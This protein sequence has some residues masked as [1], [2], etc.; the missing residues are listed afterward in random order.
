ML[1][2]TA[3][4]QR[5]VLG[6]PETIEL[7]KRV[8]YKGVYFIV[9]IVKARMWVIRIRLLLLTESAEDQDDTRYSSKGQRLSL[10]IISWYEIEYI[11]L[12]YGKMMCI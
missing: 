1:I 7:H 12:C 3:I 5:C 4:N 2:Y 11:C 9:F 10:F 8:S 6:V